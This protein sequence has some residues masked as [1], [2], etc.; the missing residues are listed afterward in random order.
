MKKKFKDI[1]KEICI[2]SKLVTIYIDV[3]GLIKWAWIKGCLEEA[4]GQVS[5][6]TR[7]LLPQVPWKPPLFR[8]ST[9]GSLHR[10]E[11]GLQRLAASGTGKSHRASG[12]APFLGSRHLATFLARGQV[13]TQPGRPL[14]QDLRK[15][16]WF[17]DSAESSLHRWE[18]GLLKQRLLW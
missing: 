10:W 3:N 1:V 8:D 17:Q 9:A 16:S 7:R 4:R 6:R 15:P 11:C 18:C 14:P 5:A 13:S 2:W 12:A